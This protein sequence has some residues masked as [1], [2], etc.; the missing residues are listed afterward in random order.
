[1]RG[2]FLAEEERNEEEVAVIYPSSTP[3]SIPICL[4]LNLKLKEFRAKGY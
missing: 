1:M 2:Y 3:P 4:P